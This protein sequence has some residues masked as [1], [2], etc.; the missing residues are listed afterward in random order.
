MDSLVR[1]GVEGVNEIKQLKRDGDI[2]IQEISE[3]S[4]KIVKENDALMEKSKTDL[5]SFI[6]SQQRILTDSMSA[7]K[8][9]VDNRYDEAVKSKVA[10]LNSYLVEAQ[11]LISLLKNQTNE[12]RKDE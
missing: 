3:K 11:N 2:A 6:N 4:E 7:L 1:Q 9:N 12:E 8:D 10:E 5:A